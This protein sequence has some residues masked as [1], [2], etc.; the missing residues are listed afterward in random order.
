MSI[1]L[2]LLLLI[3]AYYILKVIVMYTFFKPFTGK[4]HKVYVK[5]GSKTKVGKSTVK[6]T[7]DSIIIKEGFGSQSYGRGLGNVYM[8]NGA[9]VLKVEKGK[10][11]IHSGFKSYQLVIT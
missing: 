2:Y 11:F 3:L 8:A 9:N 1:L 4:I 10:I 5:E 7:K 6:I